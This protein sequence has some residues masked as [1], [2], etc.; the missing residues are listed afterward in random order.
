[1]K[2]AIN[3]ILIPIDFSDASLNALHT[4]M[5]MARRQKAQLDILYIQNIMDYYPQ[6]GQLSVN[7]FVLN[8]VHT[9]NRYILEEL[10]N[11]ISKEMQ[12]SCTPHYAIGMS[13]TV[14]YEKAGELGSDVIVT[15]RV[16]GIADKTYLFDSKAYTLVK[17]APCHVMVVPAG[18]QIASFENILLPIG[19]V[20]SVVSKYPFIQP[21]IKQNKSAVHVLGLVEKGDGNLL[22]SVCRVVSRLK[23]RIKADKLQVSAEYFYTNNAAKKV[24]DSAQITSADLL[25]INTGTDRNIWQYF[26]GSF[27]QKI[28]RNAK[29]AILCIKDGDEENIGAA[30]STYSHY[31]PIPA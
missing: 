3:N 28:I 1:M 10:A 8:E 9:K 25:V 17:N 23:A 27:T 7:D 16:P 22:S 30:Q 19:L 26:F 14:V 29:A 21:I 6:M 20:A 15:G 18:C 11:S 13:T 5:Q 4:A 31:T 24:L 2:T 12:I